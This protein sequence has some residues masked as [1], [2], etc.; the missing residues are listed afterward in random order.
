MVTDII[1]DLKDSL[2]KTRSEY[3][4]LKTKLLDYPF[5]SEKMCD[6]FVDIFEK[7]YQKKIIYQKINQFYSG[8]NISK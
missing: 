6:Q 3:I 2:E 1:D 8:E 7:I 5:N 4:K